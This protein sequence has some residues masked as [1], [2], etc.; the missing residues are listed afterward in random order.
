VKSKKV[1]VARGSGNVFR[2][3][4]HKNPDAEQLKSTLAPEI[5]KALDREGLSLRGAQGRT[6]I[7]AAEF[8]RI[9][10]AN[11]NRF[12]IDRLM[13]IVNRLGSCVDVEVRLRRRQPLEHCLLA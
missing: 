6:G 1:E 4:D 12:T 13:S 11:L 10:N 5:I 3:V 8:S 7:T 2:D 9:R